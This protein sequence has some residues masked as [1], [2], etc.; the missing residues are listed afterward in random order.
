MVD[1][2]IIFFSVLFFL[3]ISILLFIY[4]EK[5]TL[6]VDINRD[7]LAIFGAFIAALIFMFYLNLLDYSYS[8]DFKQYLRWFHEVAIIDDFSDLEREKDLG[9]SYLLYLL[10]RF[11]SSNTIFTLLLSIFV[12]LFISSISQH[13][14]VKFFNFESMFILFT[15]LLLN[16]M[17]LEHYFNIIRSFVCSAVLIYVLLKFFRS[18]YIWLALIPLMYFIHKM[19]FLLFFIFLF[20]AVILP[21]RVLIVLIII[22]VINIFT[23]ASSQ[24][25]ASQM[26]KYINYI[27]DFYSNSGLTGD[28]VF[29]FSKKLQVGFYI[30]IPLLLL[31]TQTITNWGFVSIV[32]RKDAFLIKYIYLLSGVYFLFVSVFPVADRLTVILIP[33]LYIMFIKYV[34]RKIVVTYSLCVVAFNYIALIRNSAYLNV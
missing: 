16:R 26:I 17:A 32:S 28:L 22:G 21:V 13:D 30:I 1:F 3:N 9:F 11:T 34:P 2:Y 10:S 18:K 20:L 15:I 12:L 31:Y 27:T 7:S 25:I 8:D 4:D 19:Q 23:D 5:N 29:S 6:K 33:L 24:V 14:R